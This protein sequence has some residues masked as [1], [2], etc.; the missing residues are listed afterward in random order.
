MSLLL[1]LCNVCLTPT[2][3]H[4]Y[5]H[6]YWLLCEFLVFN[7]NSID[8][9]RIDR[10]A[11]LFSLHTC[12]HCG[13]EVDALATHGLSCQQS[14]GRH[15]RHAAM[16][17]IIHCTLV[18]ANVPSRLEPSGL[19][20]ADGKCPDR[21]TVVPWRRGK[22]FVWDA[23]SPDT[24]APSYL[25][26]ATS[27]AGTVAALAENRK[28]GK[29]WCLDSTYTFTP[30]AIESSGACGPLTMGFLRDLGNRLKLTTGEEN[31]LKYLLQRLAVAVQRGNA[32]S[33]LGTTTHPSSGCM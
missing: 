18:S 33:V 31:S 28:K 16:N 14:Q 4:L 32:A 26:S 6:L 5:M 13:S 24:F 8:S 27:A 22:H 10:G 29:Y 2:V 17:N 1:I 19:E 21:V 3:H 23:T 15:H 7:S 20:R 12:C 9:T 25:Q 11:P 30:I